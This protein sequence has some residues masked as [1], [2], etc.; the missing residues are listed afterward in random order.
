MIEQ[1][2]SLSALPQHSCAKHASGT[3]AD[4]NDIVRIQVLKGVGYQR[5][6]ILK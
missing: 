2:D 3:C 5:S 6:E 4:H 1:S